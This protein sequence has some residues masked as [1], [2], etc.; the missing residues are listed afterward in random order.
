MPKAQKHESSDF[1]ELERDQARAAEGREKGKRLGSGVRDHELP[2]HTC[3]TSRGFDS[4]MD[5][6]F[7]DYGTGGDIDE[8]KEIENNWKIELRWG[9][10]V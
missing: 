6:G 10:C 5:Y 1:F 7:T 3:E 9:D 8:R 2:D 4:V